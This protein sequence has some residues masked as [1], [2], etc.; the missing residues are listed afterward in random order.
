MIE[1]RRIF[2]EGHA[3]YHVYDGEKWLELFDYKSNA[4]RFARGLAHGPVR[5]IGQAKEVAI[6]GTS[7]S[8]KPVRPR[9]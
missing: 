5:Y 1:V 2:K 3:F 8:P 9:Q 6:E 4:M 7:P